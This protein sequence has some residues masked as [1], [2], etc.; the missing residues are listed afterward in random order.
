MFLQ[1]STWQTEAATTGIYLI[2]AACHIDYLKSDI[3]TI[4]LLQST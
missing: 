1:P 2:V 3:Q 4:T